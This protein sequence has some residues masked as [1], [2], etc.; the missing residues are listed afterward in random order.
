MCLP[1]P[2]QIF[3]IDIRGYISCL[4]YCHFLVTLVRLGCFDTGLLPKLPAF[5]SM[6]SILSHPCSIQH[7]SRP[8]EDSDPTSPIQ[9]PFLS[10]GSLFPTSFP[11]YSALLPF[12]YAQIITRLTI[13][14]HLSFPLLHLVLDTPDPLMEQGHLVV[15]KL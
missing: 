14:F 6:C 4:W 3:D 9:F 5:V 11:L 2:T 13:P 1:F 15:Y 7:S 12:S 10:L 8:S